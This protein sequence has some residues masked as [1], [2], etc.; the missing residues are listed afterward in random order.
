[1]AYVHGSAIGSGLGL[2]FDGTAGV[3]RIVIQTAPAIVSGTLDQAS[4]DRILVDILDN[5]REGLVPA[6]VPVEIPA[7]PEL[8]SIALELSRDLLLERFKELAKKDRWRLIDKQVNVFRHEHVGVDTSLVPETG[9]F[10]DLFGEVFRSL[11]GQEGESVITTK[12][13][14]VV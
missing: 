7:L 9:S 11:V 10:E 3:R 1:V 2:D 13:D 5:L 8:L 12:G 4:L 14:E 6:D